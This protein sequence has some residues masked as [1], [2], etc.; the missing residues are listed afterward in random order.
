MAEK[1]TIGNAE[2]WHGDCREVLPLLPVAGAVITDPPYPNNAGLFLD[3]IGLAREVIE[4]VQSDALVFWSEL[5]IPKCPLDLVAVHV[6][7]RNNVNGRPYEP[8]FHFSTKPNK[9]R[10]EVFAHPAVFYG[11]GPGC[12]EYEG[13]PTQKPVALMERLVGK[14]NGLVLDPFMGS[15][16]TGVACMRLQRKFTG[17]ERERK[18]F[19]IA[20]RR[21]ED[22]QRQSRLAV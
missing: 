12:L 18:Y 6:W 19:D 13:H 1:V 16:S 8:I 5:E 7:H 10:S 4:G 11:A 15:G 21:I 20:C 22:E 14:T 17:I 9:R 3:S 2:L